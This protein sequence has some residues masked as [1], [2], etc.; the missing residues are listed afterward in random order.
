[1][2][3]GYRQEVLNVVLAQLL[4]ERGVIAA[5]EKVMR[6]SREATRKM[7]DL[8]VNFQGLRTIIEGEVGDQQG[9][10]E[11]A[12][13]SAS[14]RVEDGIAHIG[15]AIVYPAFL[16]KIDFDGLKEGIATCELEVAIV[17]E[18]EQ[19]GFIRG[20]VNYLESALRRTFE[21]L[22]KENVVAEAVVVLERGIEGFAGV[23]AAKEGDA[24]RVA[25]A[26]GIKDLEGA[27]P[28]EED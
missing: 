27:E 23:L 5:P 20:D 11:K 13:A 16:R 28:G 15:V 25:S 9:A 3:T 22:V 24:W 26:L 14:Q 18:S 10:H 21:N 8:V 19:T 6:I 12:I 17:T 7:P 2:N 1:M 4:Q